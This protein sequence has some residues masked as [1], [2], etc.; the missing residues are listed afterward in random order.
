MKGFRRMNAREI[1]ADRGPWKHSRLRG[2]YSR[3]VA[4][5]AEAVFGKSLSAPWTVDAGF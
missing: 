1:L 5:L 2:R 4:E 3:A